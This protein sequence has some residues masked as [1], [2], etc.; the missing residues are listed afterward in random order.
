MTTTCEYTRISPM[1]QCLSRLN[2]S[3]LHLMMVFYYSIS[4]MVKIITHFLHS[5]KRLETLSL[6]RTVCF[7]QIRSI[8]CLMCS[9]LEQFQSI[10]IVRKALFFKL[11][12]TPIYTRSFSRGFSLATSSYVLDGRT[13]LIAA[14]LN[15]K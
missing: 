12:S 1:F 4:L 3:L 10:Q 14:K 15:T 9:Q 7:L 8:S 6:G 13:A 2:F 5:V 11:I